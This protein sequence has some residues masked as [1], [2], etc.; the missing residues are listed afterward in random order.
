MQNYAN[1]LD[2][3]PVRNV[4]FSTLLFICSVFVG[5][6]VGQFVGLL[7]AIP[8][9]NVSIL[10]LQPVLENPTAYPETRI[11]FMVMQGAT[12]FMGFL[13][14]P[15]LYLVF[16][17]KIYVPIKPAAKS[18]SATSIFLAL[19]ITLSFMMANSAV[20]EWNMNVDFPEFLSGF[21]SW[22]RG[23]EDQMAELTTML[24][25]MDGVGD[26]ILALVVIAILP[27]LGE[28]FIF[29]G[30]L[31]NKLERISGNVHVA[32]WFSAF[33]FGAIHMQFYGMVPRVLL[34]AVFGYLYI[35]SN[36]KLIYPILA[37]AFN[38]GFSIIMLYMSQRGLVEYDLENQP[39]PSIY[40][41]LGCAALTIF[42]FWLYKRTFENENLNGELE[43]SI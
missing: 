21:E 32:I 38:N 11:G 7:A 41:I 20:I 27:G 23:M 35:F 22:A 30:I 24:T 31:Q 33:I 36:K 42:L 43:K 16:I 28:E 6:M 17:E 2:Q 10:E 5:L 12:S 18:I 1:S 34:G 8:F 40:V 29:R 3:T 39:S 13:V 25:K 4:W 15:Y 37:H 26:L 14:I 9:I 19:G